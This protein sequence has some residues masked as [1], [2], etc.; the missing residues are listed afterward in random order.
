MVRNTVVVAMHVQTTNART[1]AHTGIWVCH[2]SIEMTPKTNIATRNAG[3]YHAH[4]TDMRSD[5]TPKMDVY[6]QSGT[7]GYRDM[8]RAWMSGCSE[9]DRRLWIQICLRK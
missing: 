7:W 3:Q 1:R 4:Q 5:Y 9:S 2:T 8:R 6:H